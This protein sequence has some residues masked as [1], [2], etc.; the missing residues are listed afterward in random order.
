MEGTWPVSMEGKKVG[1]CAVTKQGLYYKIHCRCAVPGKELLRLR[2]G[3]E[4]LG[5]LAPVDGALG[6]ETCQPIKRFPGG[7]PSFSLWEKQRQPEGRFVPLSPGEP[8]A[9]L[10]ELGHAR[11]S[12]QNGTEGITILDKT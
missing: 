7:T 4:D 11:L 6:L 5:L 10:S 1:Q 12:Y 9:Y 2:W 3:N 8:F